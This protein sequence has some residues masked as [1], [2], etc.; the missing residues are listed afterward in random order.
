MP[1]D[2]GRLE[3]LSALVAEERRVILRTR[4]IR[5]SL[6][7]AL[8]DYA[9][10]ALR[11]DSSPQERIR[12]RR[13]WCERALQMLQ[14]VRVAS[15]R[16]REVAHEAAD[17]AR[18]EGGVLDLGE[19][20]TASHEADGAVARAEEVAQGWW[21]LASEPERVPSAGEEPA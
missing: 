8:D 5:V 4:T 13:E 6:V 7:S 3:M 2:R 16:A 1:P 14:D 18:S 19:L 11:R 17:A 21:N 20:D 15:L 12:L 10:S 9:T